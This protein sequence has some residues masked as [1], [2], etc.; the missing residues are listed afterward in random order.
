[1]FVY[2]NK[3]NNNRIISEKNKS[4]VS[5]LLAPDFLLS[6]STNHCC[7]MMCFKFLKLSKVKLKLSF[8]QLTQS[9]KTSAR[10]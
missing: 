10:V 3:K 9:I 1:M 4:Y 5:V 8:F 2:L 6:L 7:T